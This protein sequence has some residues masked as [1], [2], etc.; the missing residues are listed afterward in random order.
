MKLGELKPP[1]GARKGR[2]RVGRGPASGRGKT[3]GRGHK[4]QKSRA[5]ASI[6]RGF[7]GG[8][9]PLQRRLPKRGFKSTTNKRKEATASVKVGD[10]GRFGEGAVID[11]DFLKEKKAVKS[12]KVDYLRII[13]G[14]ELTVAVTVRAQ[15]FTPGARAAIEAAGGKVEAV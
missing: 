1:S 10:L 5:G 11:L 4:G 9:M 8:Q 12:K 2:R 13:G 14:G 6:R 15:Y 7:E 3:C